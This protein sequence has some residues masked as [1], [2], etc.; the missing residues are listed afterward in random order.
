[1]IFACLYYYIHLEQ[2]LSYRNNFKTCT[3]KLTFLGYFKNPF[4][5]LSFTYFVIYIFQSISASKLP[6]FILYLKFYVLLYKK[7]D[8]A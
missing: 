8:H 5:K 4:S 1:M 6:S 3:L 2:K 7:D